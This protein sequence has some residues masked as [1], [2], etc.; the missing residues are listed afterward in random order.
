MTISIKNL[1]ILILFV[2]FITASI[3]I[4]SSNKR[5][6]K[7]QQEI[8]T[9]VKVANGS[10]KK[11]MFENHIYIIYTNYNTSGMTHSPDCGCRNPFEMEN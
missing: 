7:P 10:W 2:V 5:N 8:E 9:S 6:E 4:S 1:S 11:V 3:L